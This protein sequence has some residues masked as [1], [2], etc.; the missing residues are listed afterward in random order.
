MRNLITDL[1]WSVKFVLDLVVTHYLQQ[2]LGINKDNL[3]LLTHTADMITVKH[4]L[5]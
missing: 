3:N 1:R 4:I 2:I 5:L